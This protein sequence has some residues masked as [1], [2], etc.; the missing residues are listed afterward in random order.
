[1]VDPMR[2]SALFELG[3]MYVVT[4]DSIGLGEVG[5]THQPIETLASLRKIPNILVIRSGDGN[6]TS[7]T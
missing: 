4:L 7:G 5:C 1:M 2:L 6:E 3:V